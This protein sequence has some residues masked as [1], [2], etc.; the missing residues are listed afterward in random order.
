MGMTRKPLTERDVDVLSRLSENEWATP[1]Q[2]GASDGSHHTQT[3]RKLIRHGLVERHERGGVTR[4][5][6]T[7]RLTPDGAAYRR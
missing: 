5:S 4:S 3:L 6:Y 7:Y 1:Y 2:I